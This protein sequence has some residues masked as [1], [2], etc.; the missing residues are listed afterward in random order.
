[1]TYDSDQQIIDFMNQNSIEV[2]TIPTYRI[3]QS[4]MENL[5][6]HDKVVF[7]H[8]INDQRLAQ[9]LLDVGVYGLYT[10]FLVPDESQ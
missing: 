6:D 2:V 4:F 9:D 10:D 1:M 7:V 8:T 3:S 5:L